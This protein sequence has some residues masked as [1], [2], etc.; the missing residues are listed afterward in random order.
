MQISQKI[1][2]YYL[3][4]I[5]ISRSDYNLGFRYVRVDGGSSHLSD[6]LSLSSI[7]RSVRVSLC[8]PYIRPI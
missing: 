3:V 7:A 6:F 4:V 5:Y 1:E 2:N 8:V